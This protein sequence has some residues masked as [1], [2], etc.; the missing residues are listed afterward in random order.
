[1]AILNT[2]L[3]VAKEEDSLTTLENL[4]KRADALTKKK[5]AAETEL[6]FL[7]S[8]H[9]EILVELKSLGITDVDNLPELIVAYEAEIKKQLQ[10]IDTSITSL[11][12][13]V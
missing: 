9:E 6:E 10:E 3:T 2:K 12:A 13:A 1:M 4:K 8:Q 7:Q 11:E 5:M